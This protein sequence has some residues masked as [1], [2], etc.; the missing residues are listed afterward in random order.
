MENKLLRRLRAN[1]QRRGAPAGAALPEEL[2]M[3]LLDR[4]RLA[5][6][7]LSPVFPSSALDTLPELS[8]EQRYALGAQALLGRNAAL[9]RAHAKVVRSRDEAAG[10]ESHDAV[11]A[12][13]AMRAKA[14]H[15]ELTSQL[16]GHHHGA[17][18]AAREAALRLAQSRHLLSHALSVLEPPDAA[19]IADAHA[20]VS[21][22]EDHDDASSH[23]Q[24][25]GADPLAHPVEAVD[26]T[27]VDG[28]AASTVEHSR[29]L[30]AHC[31]DVLERDVREIE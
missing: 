13:L 17:S 2:C 25:V 29:R 12:E 18:V 7:R 3:A 9:R 5:R 19:A 4:V 14:S 27:G 21:A 1:Q 20:C 30:R 23:A 28:L 31:E 15:A 6:S 22:E 11:L 8:A 26:W 10:L 24:P 16:R